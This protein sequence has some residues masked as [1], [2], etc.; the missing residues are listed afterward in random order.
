MKLAIL[1]DIFDLDVHVEQL[2][3]HQIEISFTWCAAC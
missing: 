1:E 2:R 3:G